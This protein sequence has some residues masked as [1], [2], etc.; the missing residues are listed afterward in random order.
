MMLLL[1][2]YLA[3][4]LMTLVTTSTMALVGRWAGVEIEEVQYG[5]ARVAKF[6]LVRLGIFPLGGFVK[7]K[8]GDLEGTEEEHAPDALRNQPKWVQILTISSGSLVALVLAFAI[9]G[10]AALPACL[11]APRQLFAGAWGPLTTAQQLLNDF[12]QVLEGRGFWAAT[13]LIYAKV[14]VL[15]LLPIPLLN[16]G[17]VLLVLFEVHK[18]PRLE[19]ALLLPAFFTMMAVYGS[20][21]VALCEFVW[22]V[23]ASRVVT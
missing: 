19:Q 11:A 7:F 10:E 9:L 20:W 16:G 4:W 15:N 5:Y 21:I 8:G 6:G 13:G 3:V 1:E 17:N 14:G 23:S 12:R 2:A 18:H 22:Q